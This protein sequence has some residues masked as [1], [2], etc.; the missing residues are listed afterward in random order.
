MGARTITISGFSKTYSITGWRVGYSVADPR[1]AD[2]IGYLNDLIYISAHSLLQW[3]VAEG[4]R[5]LSPEFY[6][7]LA[8]EYTA[9]RDLLC[10]ALERAGLPPCAPQGAYYILAD[11][12]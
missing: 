9:K 5:K 6:G 4:L 2:M 11:A 7:R 10:Q 12:S 3:G 1:W 8:T